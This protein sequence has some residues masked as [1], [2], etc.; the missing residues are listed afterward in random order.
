MEMR[1][2]VTPEVTVQ[3]FEMNDYVAATCWRVGCQN[4]TTY[5]NN[6]S[7]APYGNL[8][9]HNEGPKDQPFSHGGDCSKAENNYFQVDANNNITFEFENSSEQGELKGGLDKWIDV[10]NDG[11]V[12][13]KDV[14]YWFT[15]TGT[16][17]WNHWGYVE[18]VDDAHV[19]R[20]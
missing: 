15:Y 11:I 2:W 9:S 20:S 5:Y 12:N 14:I 4:N 16:R 7:N 6:N 8:W 17:Y 13:S 10:N 18:T 3:G 19:N 1:N